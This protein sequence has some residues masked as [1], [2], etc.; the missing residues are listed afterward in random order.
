MRLKDSSGITID[1]RPQTM[2]VKAKTPAVTS[3]AQPAPSKLSANGSLP[4][5][6]TSGPGGST[7]SEPIT[8]GPSDVAMKDDGEKPGTEITDHS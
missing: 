2:N 1:F 5:L 7:A 8:A 4:A 6:Q 3:Q